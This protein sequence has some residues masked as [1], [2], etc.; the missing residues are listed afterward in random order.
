MKRIIPLSILVSLSFITVL[1]Q[2][3][4]VHTESGVWINVVPDN[5]GF[6]LL[7]P[8]KPSEKVEPME[9]HPGVENHTLTLE[10]KLAGY[11]LSY[12]EFPDEDIGDP[13]AQLRAAREMAIQSS[14]RIP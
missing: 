10:T 7:M 11:V 1:A 12:I 5:A 9:G 8:G 14:T 3:P 6:T 4:Q 13:V 2:Q